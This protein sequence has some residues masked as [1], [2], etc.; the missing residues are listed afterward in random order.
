M[1]SESSRKCRVRERGKYFQLLTVLLPGVRRRISCLAGVLEISSPRARITWCGRRS[2][3]PTGKCRFSGFL[4]EISE[5]RVFRRSRATVVLI[6]VGFF[7]FPWTTNSSF[8][9][10]VLSKFRTFHKIREVQKTAPVKFAGAEFRFLKNQFN[11][12][13]HNLLYE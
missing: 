12:P 1:T 9:R 11:F 13:G 6:R 3:L 8:R 4:C 10:S 5:R 7:V 2:V